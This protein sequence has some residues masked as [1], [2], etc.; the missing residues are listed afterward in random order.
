MAQ[1]TP[2]HLA[3]QF[4]SGTGAAIAPTPRRRRENAMYFK[5]GKQES[6]F[7]YSFIYLFATVAGCCWGWGHTVSVG[8]FLNFHG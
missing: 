3:S 4:I 5:R 8:V 7:I 1:K 2:K 6:A